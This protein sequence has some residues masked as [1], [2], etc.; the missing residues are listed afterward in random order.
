M[1]KYK[2]P[3]KTLAHR[4]LKFHPERILFLEDIVSNLSDRCREEVYHP[5]CQSCQYPSI[6]LKNVTADDQSA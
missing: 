1:Y 4:W 2:T 6:N 5:T 3:V